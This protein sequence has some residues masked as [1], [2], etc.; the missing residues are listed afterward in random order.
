VH[1]IP[2]IDTAGIRKNDLGG[3]FW[4]AEGARIEAFKAPMGGVEFSI[5]YN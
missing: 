1:E 5:F 4:G 2:I 3:Q